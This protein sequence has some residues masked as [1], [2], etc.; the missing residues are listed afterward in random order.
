MLTLFLYCEYSHFQCKCKPNHKQT[1]A[2]KSEY[3]LKSSG[4]FTYPIQVIRL[5]KS[6]LNII[7]RLDRLPR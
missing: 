5:E 3:F 6:M 1:A 7:K 4:S 2:E